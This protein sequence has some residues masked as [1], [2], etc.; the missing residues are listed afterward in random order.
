MTH[1]TPESCVVIQQQQT[2]YFHK[3]NAAECAARGGHIE[4]GQ[5]WHALIPIL[6]AFALSFAHGAFTGLFWEVMG[7]KPA[8]RQATKE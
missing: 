5:P 1:T 8:S 2:L 7:L 4:P 3:A 6:I